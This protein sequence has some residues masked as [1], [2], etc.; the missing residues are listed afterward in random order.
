MLF[1]RY[2]E[3]ALMTLD[4]SDSIAKEHL[5]GVLSALN[6]KLRLY[7]NAHSTDKAARGLRMVL[8]A[9]ESLIK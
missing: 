4:P 2:L 7:I 8:M 9:S 5:K 3:E 1:F 6:Q